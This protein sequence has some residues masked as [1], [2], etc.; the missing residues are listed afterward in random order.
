MRKIVIFFILIPF[1]AKS[2][3]TVQQ[4]MQ[5]SKWIGTSPSGILWSYDNKSI[6]FKWNPDKNTSDSFYQYSLS[7]KKISKS[8]FKDAELAEDISEGKYN[9]AKSE[10]TFVHN[11]DIFL[12]HISTGKIIRITQTE[13]AESDPLFAN[14]DSD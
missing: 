11:D 13:E 4:I 5:D 1:I 12:L 3:L 2:Q 10:I 9:D 6:Y 7:E 14:N 8:S